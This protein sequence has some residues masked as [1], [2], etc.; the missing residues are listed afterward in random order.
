MGLQ[1]PPPSTFW[2]MFI[3]YIPA[4]S[5]GGSCPMVNSDLM[6]K[7]HNMLLQK[8]V[9]FTLNLGLLRTYNQIWVAEWGIVIGHS[10]G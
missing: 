1:P 4:V 6:I 7:K 10:R 2:I 8:E 3:L 5:L 9:Q